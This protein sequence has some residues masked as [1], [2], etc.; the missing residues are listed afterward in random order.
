MLLQSNV[1][2]WLVTLLVIIYKCFPEISNWC[3]VIRFPS[4]GMCFCCQISDIS[5]KSQISTRTGFT[6]LLFVSNKVVVGKWLLLRAADWISRL[7]FI[8]RSLWSSVFRKLYLL[9]F[10]SISTFV[11]LTML[12]NNQKFFKYHKIY[13]KYTIITVTSKSVAQSK[14][15]VNK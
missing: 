10:I 7:D 8:G 15:Y 14:Y 1:R 13:R 5:I 11:N 2:T 6:A 12:T 9:F 3:Q 4:L